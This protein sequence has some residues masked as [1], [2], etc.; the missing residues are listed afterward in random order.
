VAAAAVAAVPGIH[1][2]EAS[3]INVTNSRAG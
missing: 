2:P 3:S 1:L